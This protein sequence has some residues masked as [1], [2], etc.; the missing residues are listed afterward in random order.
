M[1]LNNH[2]KSQMCEILDFLPT[3]SFLNCI[4]AI[5]LGINHYLDT[6]KK[7][8]LQGQIQSTVNKSLE[9]ADTADPIRI[10]TI[11]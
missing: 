6:N 4:F 7:H 9:I 2:T 3:K 8:N 11:N 5:I 1:A 10:V